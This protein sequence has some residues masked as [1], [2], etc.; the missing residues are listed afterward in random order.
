MYEYFGVGLE[1]WEELLAFF[2]D[3][4]VGCPNIVCLYLP[5][6]LWRFGA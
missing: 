1:I 2:L 6:V 5:D 3:F 4:S